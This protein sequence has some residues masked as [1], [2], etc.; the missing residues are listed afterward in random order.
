MNNFNAPWKM[1]PESKDKICPWSLWIG[2]TKRLSDNCNRF[3]K[4]V[5]LKRQKM[6]KQ[7]FKTIEET[8]GNAH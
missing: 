5:I 7:L 6:C 2:L 1:L 4:I 8:I 3:K